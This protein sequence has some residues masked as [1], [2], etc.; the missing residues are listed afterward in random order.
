MSS[1]PLQNNDDKVTAVY[2]FHLQEQC[3]IT[4]PQFTWYVQSQTSR[5]TLENL[6]ETAK[7]LYTKDM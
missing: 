2:D 5:N 6:L 4:R 3:I 7:F 1:I